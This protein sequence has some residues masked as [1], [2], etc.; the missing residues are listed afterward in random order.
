MKDETRKTSRAALLPF[1]GDPFIFSYWYGWFKKGWG[2]EVDKLY[3]YI[4]STVEEPVID[5][6]KDMVKK[7]PKVNLTY[8]NHQVEH[9]DCINA[10]LDIVQEEY[11]VLMED[12]SFVWGKGIISQC[13]NQL[14]CGAKDIVGS[15]RGSC[16]TEILEA[17]KAKWGLDYEGLGD[18]GPNF[19]P[20]LFFCKK[21]LLLKTDRNFAAKAWRA[22][23]VVEPLGYTCTTDQFGDTFVNTSLQLRN[24][25][26]EDRIGYIPQYHGHPLDI[27]HYEKKQFLFDGNALWCHIGSLS[28]GISGLL[29]DDQNRPLAR[30]LIDPPAGPT[31]LPNAPTND[32]EAQEYERR[33]QWFLTFYWSAP[34]VGLAEFKR[35]YKEAIDQVVEQFKL[36]RKRIE[37]RR[38]IYSA[39]MNGDIRT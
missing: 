5:F 10:L 26:P 4:N 3:L 6:I 38:Q 14:E 15:K 9:G 2:S 22:G 34:A 31:V 18:Q 30:R 35:L 7:D 28:S 23:E 36:N 39:L 21:E 32:F 12:D 27:E 1:P 37:R 11:V 13:F 20:N 25:V 8:V 24:I 19:W 16:G 17:A 29:R 33:M